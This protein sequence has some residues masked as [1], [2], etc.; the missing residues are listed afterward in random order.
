MPIQDA[1][2]L[3]TFLVDFTKAV[4]RFSPGAPIVGGKTEVAA[5]TK[6]ESF[7]WVS[8]KHYYDATLNPPY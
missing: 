4:V 6:H 3:A 8:R 1:V 5:I 2:D 7:K